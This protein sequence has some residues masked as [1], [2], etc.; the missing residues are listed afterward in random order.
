VSEVEWLTLEQAAEYAG[1]QPSTLRTWMRSGLFVAFDSPHRGLLIT[2]PELDAGMM[3]MAQKRAEG[4][5]TARANP[6]PP[7]PPGE[8]RK[9][10]RPRLYPLRRVG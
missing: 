3:R 9:P 6:P 4:M 7:P 10:G 2:R 1:C 5:Q 8:K